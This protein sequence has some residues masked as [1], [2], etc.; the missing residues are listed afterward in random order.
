M[1]IQNY[2]NIRLIHLFA[3]SGLR[4]GVEDGSNFF[5]F[6]ELQRD[7]DQLNCSFAQFFHHFELFTH[8]GGGDG[9]LNLALLR[10]TYRAGDPLNRHNRNFRK[11]GGR[12]VRCLTFTG[13]RSVRCLSVTNILTVVQTGSRW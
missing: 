12:R 10:S 7:F 6:C 8:D 2:K 13:V 4:G 3:G 5:R 1:K 11:S 9:I